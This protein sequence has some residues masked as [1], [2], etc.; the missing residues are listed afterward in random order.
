MF[1]TL[2]RAVRRTDS[3]LNALTGVGL[4]RGKSAM[5]FRASASDYL[6][7]RTLEDLYELDGVASRIVRAPCVHALRHGVIVST[8]DPQVDT[9][10]KA[11]MEELD[12]VNA[13]RKAWQWARLYGGGAVFVGADDGKD[14]A[15]PLDLDA[16]QSVRFT[17]D[18]DRIE[19]QP[20]DWETDPLKSTFGKPRTYRLTRNATGGGSQHAQVHASRLI[21][22]D[23]VEPTKRRRQY[24]HGWGDSVLQRVY[25]DL[26]QARGAYAAVAGLMHESSQG[27][28]KMKDLMSMISG[29]KDDT[30]KRRMELMD[31]SRSVARAILIDEDET[32]ER[33]EV[34]ALTGLVEA[35][36]RFTN[37][38]SASSEIPVT[39]LMGQAPAGLNAT[40]ESDIRS[41]YDAVAA[42]REA[43]LRSRVERMVK[44]LLRAKDGPTGGVEPPGWKVTFPPLWQST[45]SEDADLRQ[46][47]AATDQI[48]IDKGVITPEEVAL[49]RFRSEGW[50]PDTTIDLEARESALKGGGGMGE[51]EGTEDDPEDSAGAPKPDHDAVTAIIGK[52]AA[53]EIP[54]DAGVQLLAAHV[55]DK[56]EAVM[57]EAG[58][59]F[60]TAPEPGHAAEMD[61]L[62]AENAKLARSQQSTKAMLS[63]VLERNRAGELVVKPIGPAAEKAAE[64]IDVGDVV[65][66][67]EEPGEGVTQDAHADAA[68]VPVAIVFPLPA[69]TARAAAVPGGEPVADLHMTVAFLGR[70]A[71]TADEVSAIET[72][73]RA[74]AADRKPIAAVLGLT[75]RFVGKDAAKGDPVFRSVIVRGADRLALVEALD[76]AGFPLRTEHAWVPHVTV[77]YIPQG[78]SMPASVTRD[79]RVEF[80]FDRVALWAGERRVEVMFGGAEMASSPKDAVE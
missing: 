38:V 33:I 65:E 58:R 6:D 10:I 41:W 49:N 36:D 52:V 66:V 53:R 64:G 60:F 37:M 39:V 62:R 46:K 15:L 27:V 7:D 48:Y 79:N 19:L 70:R 47:V 12:A 35:M 30:F 74:W 29:D 13:L 17:V 78:S 31:M 76:D 2:R 22:F 24:L 21:R 68:E 1:D 40:G 23:G 50:S 16:I 75:N 11:R 67:A 5:V 63:R 56:A 45:P 43:M 9:K 61:S 3:W 72:V 57:G 54:R 28:F 59:T 34:G 14:P 26:Q 25:V 71:L 42:E 80:A 18:T 51:G 55:G 77:A 4:N 73:L 20:S 8:G 69:D 32:Y 44:L